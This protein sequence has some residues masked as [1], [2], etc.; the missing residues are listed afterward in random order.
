[1]SK[2][3]EQIFSEIERLGG[4]ITTYELMNMQPR[5]SQYQRVLSQ[6]RKKVAVFGWVLTEAE[7]VLNTRGCFMYRLIKPPVQSEMFS[8]NTKHNAA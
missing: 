8:D 7:P 6:L 2:Q 5:I 1:M 3:E 4:R